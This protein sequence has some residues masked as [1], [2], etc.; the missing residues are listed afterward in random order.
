MKLF[1]L[2]KLVTLM[3]IISVFLFYISVTVY[4]WN[5][6]DFARDFQWTILLLQLLS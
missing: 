2:V 1:D 3:F 5:N 6:W 4:G